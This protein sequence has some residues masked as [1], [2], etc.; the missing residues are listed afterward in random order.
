M[1]EVTFY[2]QDPIGVKCVC[3][4]N[5]GYPISTEWWYKHTSKEHDYYHRIKNWFN[6]K[7]KPQGDKD[8]PR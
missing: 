7:T 1:T 6:R 2:K 3:G 8:D 5:S 4:S